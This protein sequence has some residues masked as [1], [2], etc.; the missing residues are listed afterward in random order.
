[1]GQTDVWTDLRDQLQKVG[2]DIGEH[3]D[4]ARLFR[5][6]ARWSPEQFDTMKR[7]LGA[8]G[9]RWLS[10]ISQLA[11]TSA[12]DEMFEEC[13]LTAERICEVHQPVAAL[14]DEFSP[15][16][17]TCDYLQRHLKDCQVEMVPGA[18]HLAPVQ[19]PTAFVE[20][21][22]K[23]LQRVAGATPRVRE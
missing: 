10:Q 11:N 13:G 22:R 23:H 1:M 19:N 20:L 4:F 15:F 12:G 17:A 14:Y 6:I 18:K 9:T 7:E 3:V 16:E 5:E 2:T 8:P 21:V